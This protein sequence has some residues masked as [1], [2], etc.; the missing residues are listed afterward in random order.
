MAPPLRIVVAGCGGIAQAWLDPLAKRADA[1][2]VGLVDLEPARARERAA[3][4]APAA[5]I[6]SDLAAMID[7]QRPD[8][9]IDL[10]V[11]EAHAEVA[12][13][14][15]ARGCHVLAEKPMAADMAGARRV[16]AAAHRAK[17]VHAVMQNRRFLPGVRRFRELVRGGAIGRLCE[18][19]ADFFVG[20]H[21]GGFREQMAQVLLLDMAI[22]SVDQ[23]RY[24]GDLQPL[25][26]WAQTWSPPQSWY[27]G[28]ASALLGVECAGGVR[29][30]YRGSWCAEG[31]P[32]SWECQWRAVGERGTA[33][34]DGADGIQAEQVDP[35]ATGFYRPATA[36]PLPPPIAMPLTGHAGCIDEML[37]AI[38]AG[39]QPM[40]C[41]EDN[42]RSLAIIHAAIR[43]AGSGGGRVAID[44]LE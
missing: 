34:W 38:A 28:H 14:A 32:T 39:R 1:Q 11:P 6:G 35:A 29:L 30:T 8:I 15:L 9:V 33:L 7:D 40:T 22:H 2:V 12:C 31:A 25:A 42:I 10:T 13:L 20:P 17:R 43:S 26:V 21:F 23:A 5:A 16:L 41:G 24:I 37:A 19:H 4:Y 3:A 27:R 18:L 36:A 44:D